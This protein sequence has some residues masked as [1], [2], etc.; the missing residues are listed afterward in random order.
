MSQEE[1]LFKK[2]LGDLISGREFAF[3]EPA[4]N[5]MSN[6]LDVKKKR[7]RAILIFWFG[8]GTVLVGLSAWFL[9]IDG[10]SAKN[11]LTTNTEHEQRKSIKSQNTLDQ[12]AA[13]PSTTILPDANDPAKLNSNPDKTSTK[14]IPNADAAQIIS[15]PSREVK[16]PVSKTP[17]SNPITKEDPQGQS[18]KLNAVG[19]VKVAA[20][21]VTTAPD[22]LQN[23][24]E[25]TIAS[26]S[27]NP[28]STGATIDLPEKVTITEEVPDNVINN[29]DK[30]EEPIV[31]APISEDNVTAILNEPLKIDTSI[32]AQNLKPDTDYVKTNRPDMRIELGGTLLSG[33]A[34]TKGRDAAGFNPLAGIVYNLRLGNDFKIG[35]GI[36]YTMI[37]HLKYSE[38]TATVTRLDL[39]R[40][41]KASVFAPQ[42]IHYVLIPLK[43]HYKVDEKQSAGFGLNAAYLLTVDGK[44]NEYSESKTG[45][46]DQ[47]VSKTKGY[48]EGFNNY[49]AQITL[50]YQRKLAPHF[51]IN[52]ELMYGLMDIK[53]GQVIKSSGVERNSGLKLSVLYSLF[54]K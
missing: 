49:N 40:N 19:P 52:G 30:I 7:R 13:D 21:I 15:T 33:W 4:W 38:Y 46:T 6:L 39:G 17:S 51:Y 25:G 1:E 42:R 44:L 8:L 50:F 27:G 24:I 47:K 16:V 34:D 23:P 9:T 35:L 5:E 31:L 45:Q 22:K 41:I 48:T 28:T 54:E 12:F 18:T 29:Q 37:A 11:A 3:E 26:N 43:F 53:N 2:Q 10:V 32:A 36:Q 20:P 14:N